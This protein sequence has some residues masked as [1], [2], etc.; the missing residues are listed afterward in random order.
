MQSA[1]PLFVL[2]LV[3]C[4]SREAPAPSVVRVAGDAAVAAPITPA[5][6]SPHTGRVQLVAATERGDAV[7]SFDNAGAMRLWPA[8]DGVQEPVVVRAAVPKQLALERD[9]A[10]LVAAVLDEVGGIEVLRFDARGG[11]LGR[12]KIAPEP[13]N[14]E[15]V[16]VGAHVIARRSDQ[17]LARFDARGT[18]RG[19]LVADPGQQLG[20]LAARRG[21]LIVGA[22]A[23]AR[24]VT[25]GE[26]L[27]WGKTIQL[28]MPLVDIALAPGHHRVAG[29]LADGRA[30]IVELEPRAKVLNTFVPLIGQRFISKHG[31]PLP[32]PRPLIGFTDDDHVVA[33]GP[34]LRWA[35][36]PTWEAIED[37]QIRRGF[38]TH[39]AIGDVAISGD[40]G[41]LAISRPGKQQ[42]LGYRKLGHDHDIIGHPITRGIREVFWL[43]DKL[44]AR[45]VTKQ[46]EYFANDSPG[47]EPS[48]L[49]ALDDRRLVMSR[50]SSHEYFKA[51]QRVF[52]HDVTTGK[53]FDVGELVR[54]H[55]H[56]AYDHGTGVI[57]LRVDPNVHRFR[58]A[59]GNATKLRPLAGAADSLRPINLTDP[60]LANGVVAV[61]AT[62]E[63]F[64][65]VFEV[66]AQGDVDGKPIAARKLKLAAD[67][68]VLGVD[69]AGTIYT[70]NRV[71]V[72]LYRAGE[73]AAPPVRWPIADA[74]LAAASRDRKHVAFAIGNNVAVVVDGKER[75]RAPV[76][77]IRHFAFGATD[78]VLYVSAAGGLLAFDAATGERV[79]AAC[80]WGLGLYDMPEP[81]MAPNVPSAC[82]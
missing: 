39:A 36:A 21:A 8:L 12:A 23:A 65:R 13:A 80:G 58:I 73:P 16:I 50:S 10:G 55:S 54:G 51:K 19:T 79:A 40:G 64:V 32:A 42:F 38:E 15:I 45:R 66:P 14:E 76:E 4:G 47:P 67:L 72:V 75:W 11:L 63:G 20:S 22:G 35:A 30:A 27:A 82:H 7:L 46:S 57:A 6:T 69:V 62:Y 78:R 77:H 68:N 43:D 17:S 18:L 56:V 1:S 29:F 60:S 37:A 71:E 41:G 81:A 59:D 26:P 53:A 9:G 25:L 33:S 70:G 44:R 74:W 52:V 48:V 61:V 24:F 3:A 28:P 34:E 49:F 5:V 2:V 31:P